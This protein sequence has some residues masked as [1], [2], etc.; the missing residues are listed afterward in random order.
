MP[1]PVDGSLTVTVMGGET[2]VCP[3]CVLAVAVSEYCA[4][5]GR[6]QL[7]VVIDWG[8]L[9]SPMSKLSPVHKL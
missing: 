1:F 4:F 7:S 6:F 9:V 8:S 3:D 2:S 5:A